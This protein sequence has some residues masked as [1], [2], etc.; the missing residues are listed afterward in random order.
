M[1]YRTKVLEIMKSE[2]QV[3]QQIKDYAR[4][5]SGSRMVFSLD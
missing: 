3:I 5:D 1:D 4:L 2:S